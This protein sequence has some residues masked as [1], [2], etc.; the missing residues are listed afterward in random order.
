[1]SESHGLFGA[2]GKLLKLD[3]SNY[4]NWSFE[5]Q[6]LLEEAGVWGVVSGD[7]TQPEDRTALSKWNEKSAYG[8]RLLVQTLGDGEKS[9]IRS[10]HARAERGPATWASI[11]TRHGKSTT[12][13]RVEIMKRMI[14]TVYE[15][16]KGMSEYCATI[17]KCGD[18][19]TG[20]G[21]KVGENFL[22]DIMLANVPTEFRSY[23]ATIMLADKLPSVLDLTKL[24]CDYERSRKE[25][26][27]EDMPAANRARTGGSGKKG[28]RKRKCHRCHKTGHIAKD[29]TAPEPV[30]SSSDSDSADNTTNAKANAAYAR[31]AHWDRWDPAWDDTFQDVRKIAKTASQPRSA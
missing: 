26:D 19:L 4:H 9:H 20:I 27:G 16:E 18:E 14:H 2:A 5:V 10:L 7:E 1:M 25:G 8:Y 17:I 3:A 12:V 6:I 28:G 13:V 29:C 31:R 15:E 24:L 22:Q 11:K 21:E 23:A 30:E